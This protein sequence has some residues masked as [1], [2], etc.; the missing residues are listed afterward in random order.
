MSDIPLCLKSWL[1]L[2]L[3]SIEQKKFNDKEK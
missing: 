2:V 3:E 1:Y